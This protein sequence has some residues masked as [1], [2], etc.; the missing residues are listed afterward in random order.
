MTTRK[1]ATDNMRSPTSNGLLV[2]TVRRDRIPKRSIRG[3][4]VNACCGPTSRPIWK[5]EISTTAAAANRYSQNGSGRFWLCPSPW[6]RAWPG[7]TTRSSSS[8]KARTAQR[9]ITPLPRLHEEHAQLLTRLLVLDLE[10]ARNRCLERELCRLPWF[11]LCF[12][13]VAVQVKLHGT[14]GG[15]P[16]PHLIA[17]ING[18]DLARCHAALCDRK[19]ERFLLRPIRGGFAG[20]NALRRRSRAQQ[21][22]QP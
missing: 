9:R 16:K 5:K 20:L 12:E 7:V 22:K 6:A 14:V 18:S 19:V 15:Y 17:F 8:A 1:R 11:D 2:N 21:E 3:Y 4:R 10:A 13:V